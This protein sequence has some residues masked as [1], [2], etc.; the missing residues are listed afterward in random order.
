[1]SWERA[2]D[3]RSSAPRDS[4]F[5]SIQFGVGGAGEVLAGA[6]RWPVG[7]LAGRAQMAPVALAAALAAASAAPWPLHSITRVREERLL[8]H[9][10]PGATARPP[11]RLGQPAGRPTASLPAAPARCRV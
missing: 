5:N 9:G 6:V 4:S 3:V 8:N 10:P 7:R 11:P 2:E 1:M